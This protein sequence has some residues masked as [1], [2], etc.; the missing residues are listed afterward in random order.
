MDIN[1]LERVL[2]S[3][4]LAK[5]D[6][7]ISIIENQLSWGA[8]NTVAIIYKK[9][10]TYCFINSNYSSYKDTLIL[11]NFNWQKVLSSIEKLQ[12]EQ[13]LPAYQAK[14]IENDTIWSKLETKEYYRSWEGRL[15][16]PEEHKVWSSSQYMFDTNPSL[17]KTKLTQYLLD[18]TIYGLQ[19]GSFDFGKRKR[20]KTKTNANKK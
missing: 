16:L 17:T 5:S 2:V 15:Y 4:T 3:S 8:E 19:L 14:V 6:T 7:V 9:G 11:E 10:K 12:L 13:P 20:Q 1:Q 18:S